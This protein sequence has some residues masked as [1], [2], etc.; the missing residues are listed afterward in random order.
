M[1]A[2]A[3]EQRPQFFACKFVRLLAD[4]EAANTIGAD[5]CWLLAVIAATED[6]AGYRRPVTYF[7]AQLLARLGL[8]SEDTLARIRTKVVSAGWLSYTPG[9]KGVP[10]T[11]FVLVPD[12]HRGRLNGRADERPAKR[13]GGFPPQ[14]CGDNAGERAVSPAVVRGQPRE[15]DIFPR[16]GAGTNAG[17]SADHSSLPSPSPQK[18][19]AA[20]PPAG[21]GNK[22]AGTNTKPSKLVR[23]PPGESGATP[24]KKT[25][26]GPHPEAVAV[27]CEAWTAKYGK[28][29]SFTGK[30][31]AAVKWMLGELGG[32][33]GKFRLTV[34]RYLADP[35]PFLA[36][37]QHSLGLLRSQFN[38]HKPADRS[39]ANPL[40]VPGTRGAVYDHLPPTTTP[41][42]RG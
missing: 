41:N 35:D 9:R 31:G 32:D 13:P 27:W 37:N 12:Q 24:R 17:T 42:P 14:E 39:A 36:K 19:S 38:T 21:E 25:L 23:E 34:T 6:A 30:D 15:D 2:P 7:N 5:G 18:S 8:A 1:N 29:Y 20:G 3:H 26:A 11:Y 40:L 16:S 33:V 22:P 4:V 28:K 10:G